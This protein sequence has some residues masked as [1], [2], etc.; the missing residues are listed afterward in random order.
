MNRDKIRR[1]T[2]RLQQPYQFRRFV[3]ISYACAACQCCREF[4]QLCSA[5]KEDERL[6]DSSIEAHRSVGIVLVL[7]C[8]LRCLLAFEKTKRYLIL[9]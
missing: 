5:D 7:Q 3:S 9:P 4:P 8:G 6:L 1:F 2:S